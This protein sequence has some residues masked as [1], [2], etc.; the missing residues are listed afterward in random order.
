LAPEFLRNIPWRTDIFNL[1]E[2]GGEI[3]LRFAPD[4]TIPLAHITDTR[5]RNS[6][7]VHCTKIKSQIYFTTHES[8]MVSEI[9]SIVEKNGKNILRNAVKNDFRICP[10]WSIAA[11]C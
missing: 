11:C 9:K 5:R 1:L 3:D 6:R 4:E 10:P 2:K 7:H 8:L